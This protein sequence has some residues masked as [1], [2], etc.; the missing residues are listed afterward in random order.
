M[1][2]KT[3]SQ[4]NLQ[5]SSLIEYK[6]NQNTIESIDDILDVFYEVIDWFT[7]SKDHVWYAIAQYSIKKFTSDK[8]IKIIKEYDNIWYKNLSDE[9]RIWYKDIILWVL[10]Q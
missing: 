3:L 6:F 7:N 10:K 5:I 4:I 9:Q 1:E 8:L 2:R